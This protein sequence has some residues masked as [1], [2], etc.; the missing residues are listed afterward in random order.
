MRG[1]IPAILLATAAPA[2]A[3]TPAEIDAAVA[4]DWATHLAPLYD[5]F[6][7]NPELSAVE[8]NTAARMAKELRAVKGM[9]VTEKVGGTGVVGVL[10]NGPGP[11][12]LL[13]ADMD[14]LPVE[15]KSGLANASKVRQKDRAGVEQPV[16]HA[17]GHDT[18]ITG[19]V[20]T[21]RQLT[22]LKDKW[23]G[24]VLFVVQPAEE[25][26][27]GAK[28]MMAD[29]LYQRFGKPDYAIGWH[30]A[31]GIPT[32]TIGLADGVTYSAA[33]TLDI[34]VPGIGAHGASPHSGKD[35]VFIASD[36]VQ[37]LQGFI[38]REIAP[39][40]PAVIT[41]GAFHAGS[42]HNIISDRAELSITVRA[43]DLETRNQLIEGIKRIAVQT[44]RKWGLPEDKLP[45][46]TVREDERALPNIN[47]PELTRRLQGAFAKAYG[48]RIFTR[49]PREGMGAE[50]F[51]YLVGP[52]VKGAYYNVGGTP[53][54]DIDAEKAGGPA[55]PSHHSPLFKVDGEAAVKL[56]AQ[57]MT[58]AVL[59]LAAKPAQ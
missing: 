9:E 5:H 38:G 53:Q 44:G 46:V 24:T 15:E 8:V 28:K 18:H 4:K 56:G 57:T 21:A 7:R 23:S 22:A 19:L 58:I 13:R 14:G 50:D 39:L 27:G 12:I 55:V 16:M 49:A 36:I 1:L 32:G 35:P 54:A 3:V 29:N 48:D 45:V 52:G 47:D 6:H 37:S 51:P 41:V 11:V 31:A 34:V 33:D 40:K 42:K 2:A 17:C 20:G 59:E 26:V 25:I 30:V 43:D 10:R